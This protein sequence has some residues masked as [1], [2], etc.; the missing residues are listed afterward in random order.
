MSEHTLPHDIQLSECGFVFRRKVCVLVTLVCAVGRSMQKWHWDRE[1]TVEVHASILICLMT[2]E[3]IVLLLKTRGRV[4]FSFLVFWSILVCEKSSA[5][6]LR[7]VYV[8]VCGWLT[9][10]NGMFL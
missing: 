4:H 9:S 2:S 8:C 1:G 7:D 10:L 3:M 5:H 6:A